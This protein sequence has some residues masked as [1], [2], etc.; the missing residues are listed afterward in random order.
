MLNNGVVDLFC[1]AKSYAEGLF[2]RELRTAAHASWA[3]SPTIDL[4]NT[5]K[6]PSN[7]NQYE[8]TSNFVWGNT[9][10]QASAACYD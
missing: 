9:V 10:H 7:P 4:W 1:D 8:Y 2:G 6:Q 3:Q 5:E